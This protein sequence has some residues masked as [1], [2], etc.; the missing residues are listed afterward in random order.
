[1]EF[2]IKGN[3]T[4]IFNK[5]I[6]YG[7]VVVGDGKIKSINKI[8]EVKIDSVTNKVFRGVSLDSDS[9]YQSIIANGG[10]FQITTLPEGLI[11]AQF[12]DRLTHFEILTSRA[13]PMDEYVR[14]LGQIVLKKI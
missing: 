12:G 4:D 3:V 8:G 9:T 6:F 2:S 10:A 5:I 11:I 13:M 1:M 14:L 7:E